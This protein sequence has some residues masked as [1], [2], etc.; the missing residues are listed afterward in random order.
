MWTSWLCASALACYV[1]VLRLKLGTR[2]SIWVILS[3]DHTHQCSPSCRPINWYLWVRQLLRVAL[4]GRWRLPE[5]NNVAILV[6]EIYIGPMPQIH[7]T[8]L[9]HNCQFFLVSPRKGHLI[10]T[11]PILQRTYTFTFTLFSIFLDM[12]IDVD[13]KKV[14]ISAHVYGNSD[15]RSTSTC[16]DLCEWKT[17]HTALNSPWQWWQSQSWPFP[18]QKQVGLRLAGEGRGREE[19]MQRK[20]WE[21][22]RRGEKIIKEGVNYSFL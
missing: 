10:R 16:I 14:R 4:Q 21:G 2:E 1:G 12:V 13:D 8:K 9:Y 7:S 18:C 19:R 11:R 15:I 3:S 6:A 17:S 20:E 22:M 5:G